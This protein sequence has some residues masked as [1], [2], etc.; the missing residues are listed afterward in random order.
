MTLSRLR[1]RQWQACIYRFGID[2]ESCETSCS[3]S[4][5]L[6]CA[7]EKSA[8]AFE[9]SNLRDILAHALTG[10]EAWYPH[11]LQS[12]QRQ[13]RRAH[14]ATDHAR[15]GR[16]KQ[17]RGAAHRRPQLTRLFRWRAGSC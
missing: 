9:S 7:P 17:R 6:A 15:A 1:L 5:M 13:C 8:F 2:K 4:A 12:R 10:S 14:W 16:V 3:V 11:S